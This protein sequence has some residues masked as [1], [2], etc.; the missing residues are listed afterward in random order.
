MTISKNTHI[1]EVVKL[2]FATATYVREQIILIFAAEEIK[3]FQ[4]H[5][6]MPESIPHN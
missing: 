4:K 2:N 3:P 1:G 5:V 6:K